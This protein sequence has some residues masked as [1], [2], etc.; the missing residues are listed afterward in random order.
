M[1]VHYKST[2]NIYTLMINLKIALIIYLN[3]VYVKQINLPKYGKIHIK[4]IKQ[5]LLGIM[6]SS[7]QTYFYF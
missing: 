6:P 1:H 2:Y 7:S 3:S 5:S 4:Q